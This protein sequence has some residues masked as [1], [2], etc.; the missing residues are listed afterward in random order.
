MKF[1]WNHTIV[2]SFVLC[3]ALLLTACTNNDTTEESEETMV[4]HSINGDIT[5]NK[6]PK[7]IVTD[8]YL[9]YLL[10][11]NVKPVGSN[12]A[13]LKTLIYLKR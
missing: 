11:L 7:R 2:A 5:Y 8:F 9:G 3:A 4:Y 10:A 6:N 12:E 1:N 13:Q